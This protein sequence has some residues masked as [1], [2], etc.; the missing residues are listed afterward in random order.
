MTSLGE[1]GAS[2]AAR[3][4]VEPPN[5]TSGS[6]SSI[7]ARQLAARLR[8]DAVAATS[9]S[10]SSRRRWPHLRSHLRS[11]TR[12]TS[13]FR[14]QARL[15][16]SVPLEV[17]WRSRTG[18]QCSCQ[19][20]HGLGVANTW[21]LPGALARAPSTSLLRF[22]EGD[23]SAPLPHGRAR[24]AQQTLDAFPELGACTT[25]C[26]TSSAIV[27]VAE[28]AL[29]G[30]ARVSGARPCR[31]AVAS[32]CSSTA[33]MAL[34]VSRE[35]TTAAAWRDEGQRGAIPAANGACSA[36]HDALRAYSA[37]TLDDLERGLVVR[38]QLDVAG[39]ER[40]HALRP[41]A[42]RGP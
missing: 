26:S 25:H 38:R 40:R 29:R 3:H 21:R 2:A 14:V 42:P 13:L 35:L 16:G 30:R 28:V 39:A 1:N 15:G 23:L 19:T 22:L 17:G 9:R 24:V 5:R 32:N 34:R 31:R 18:C 7:V 12:D 8:V 36:R 6:R 41:S 27:A 4:D 37:V 33:A 10:R 11:G 20:E